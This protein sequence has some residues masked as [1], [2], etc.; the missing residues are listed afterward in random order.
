MSK[1]HFSY[2]RST[3][4][5]NPGN[6]SV[7]T[8]YAVRTNRTK[9]TAQAQLLSHKKSYRAWGRRRGARSTTSVQSTSP[10]HARDKMDSMTSS[11]S[12]AYYCYKKYWFQ[13]KTR[14]WSKLVYN[15]RWSWCTTRVYYSYSWRWN[16]NSCVNSRRFIIAI[17]KTLP[18]KHIQ[19]SIHKKFF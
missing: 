1:T 10:E 7:K 13:R 19:E 18:P 2:Q 16:R 14:K 4:Q 6:H 17:A 11:C 9:N 12:R 3:R 15:Q 5:V 8:M